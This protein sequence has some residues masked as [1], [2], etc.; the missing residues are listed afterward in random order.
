[1]D[2]DRHRSSQDAAVRRDLPLS[3]DDP[4]TRSPADRFNPDKQA[5]LDH[6]LD[7]SKAGMAAGPC[8]RAAGMEALLIDPPR[9]F[10]GRLPSKRSGDVNQPARAIP[11]HQADDAQ[12]ETELASGG[13]RV[14]DPERRPGRR[15]SSDS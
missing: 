12:G 11:V 7:R 4:V 14:G 13:G 5:V 15:P 6:S 8:D 3:H 9:Q 10:A 2:R 1:M